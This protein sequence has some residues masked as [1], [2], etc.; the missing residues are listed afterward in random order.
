MTPQEFVA[1]WENSTLTERA[2]AQTHLN[3]LYRLLDVPTHVETDAAGEHYAFERRVQDTAQGTGFA[4]VWKRN[5]IAGER[6][7]PR[8]DLDDANPLLLP[9]RIDLGSPFRIY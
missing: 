2:S 7:A 4:G 5:A 8:G 3:D 1:T 9:H 6:K